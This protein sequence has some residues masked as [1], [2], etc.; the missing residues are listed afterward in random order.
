MGL[1]KP[2]PLRITETADARLSR[3]SLRSGMTKA[4]LIRLAVD[5]FLSEVEK[6]GKI[7]QTVRLA[8]DVAQYNAKTQN[9]TSAPVG[10]PTEPAHYKRR[11]KKKAE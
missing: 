6:T 4:E 8:E 2:I 3:M 7:V 9:F 11:R 1:R 5:E 10:A